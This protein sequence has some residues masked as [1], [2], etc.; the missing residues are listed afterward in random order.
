MILTCP[1]CATSY[2]V[3]DARIPE[4]GR[5]VKCSSCGARWTAKKESGLA[6][7]RPETPEA[8]NPAEIPAPAEAAAGPAD[9][10]P[11]DDLEFVPV[12][13]EPEPALRRRAAPRPPP[14]AKTEA[15]GK[16]FVW[17]SAAVVAVALVAGALIFRAEVVRIWPKS[18]AA[19]AGL[20]LPVNSVGLVIEGV[21][22]QPTFVGGR[23]V[24]AVTGAVRNV[25]QE[26]VTSPAIRVNLL[27]HA[28]KPV[29]GKILRPVDALVPAGATRHFALSISDPPSNARELE[30]LFDLAPEHA[31]SAPA[32][33]APAPAA[34]DAQ[35]LPAGSPE[36]LSEHG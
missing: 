23:P 13:R 7:T 19:Y 10:A 2:F 28:G 26:A 22:A 9:V 8:S 34:I 32:V 36:A 12:E 20:G 21:H 15:G 25:R 11:E 16:V 14:S 27:N 1:E 24:L 35:P 17:A 6:E 5:T 18:G 3:D 4:A 31:A 29:A 33:H 30:V